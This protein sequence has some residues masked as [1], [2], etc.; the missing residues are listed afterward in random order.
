MESHSCRNSID[1]WFFKVV[2]MIILEWNIK[3]GGSEDRIPKILG[4]IRTHNADIVVITEFRTTHQESLINGLQEMGYFQFISSNPAPKTN[5]I[6]VASKLEILPIDPSYVEDGVKQR[7]LEVEVVDR[8]FRLLCLHIPGAGDVWGKEAFWRSVVEYAKD[9]KTA[10]VIMIGDFNTGLDIDAQGT[11]FKFSN[12]MKDLQG[13]GWTDVWRD[14]NPGKR[15]Y[16]WYSNAGNGF[17]LDY[18]YASQSMRNEVKEVSYS[19]V[20]RENGFSDHSLLKTT[21]VKGEFEPFL[22]NTPH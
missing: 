9:H 5:G 19:H 7:W 20:E 2:K 13:L 10:R 6:L 16:S 12:Y 15:E 18:T 21:I 4:S 8:R 11:P 1:N 3:H 22:N 17:R 14:N